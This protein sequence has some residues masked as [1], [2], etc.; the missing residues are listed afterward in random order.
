L[1]RWEAPPDTWSPTVNPPLLAGLDLLRPNDPGYDDARRVFNGAIDR[2]PAVIARCND[3][4]DVAVAIALARDSGLPLAVHGGGHSVA[5][6]AVC[7]GGVMIDL[8]PMK[9][10]LVDPLAGTARVEAGC[11]WGELD[12]ATQLH[13][14]AVTGGRVSST[15]VAGLTLGSGSGGSSASSASPVT[16]CSRS[17]SS[18]PRASRS[19]PARLSTPSGSGAC[20]AAAAI[21]ASSPPSTSACTW[22]DR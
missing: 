10:I 22:S 17:S 13:G 21:S 9:G 11:T 3:A 2:R 18:P 5:G 4:A 16:T 1:L 15:G 8:R 19:A 7:D 12:A 6:H 20:V 14:L